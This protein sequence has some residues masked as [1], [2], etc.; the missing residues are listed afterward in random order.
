MHLFPL[1]D[2]SAAEA[3]RSQLPINTSRSTLQAILEAVRYLRT[4]SMSVEFTQHY[5]KNNGRRYDANQRNLGWKIC[6]SILCLVCLRTDDVGDAKGNRDDST[7]GH[8]LR[9]AF[10]ISANPIVDNGQGR[11]NLD[12]ISLDLPHTHE[13]QTYKVDQIDTSERPRW[14]TDTLERK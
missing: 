14:T 13:Q 7:R 11:H 10:V 3:I 2:P 5:R 9:M 4:V 12:H 6:W 8:L 1:T